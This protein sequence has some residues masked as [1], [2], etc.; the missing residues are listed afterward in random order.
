LN[1]KSRD[2]IPAFFICGATKDRYMVTIKPG[3][4]CHY[5]GSEY[6]VLDVATHSETEEQVVVYRCLY[7]DYSMWVRPLNM[8]IE[9][10]M[11]DGVERPRFRFVREG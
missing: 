10:V 8:F 2:I 4:Y 6:Q 3:I 7:G 9:N 11:V 1:G 5:K